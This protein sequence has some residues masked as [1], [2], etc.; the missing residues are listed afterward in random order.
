MIIPLTQH[1]G[2]Q[3]PPDVSLVIYKTYQTYS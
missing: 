2:N 3:N 1:D